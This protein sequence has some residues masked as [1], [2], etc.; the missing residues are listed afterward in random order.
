[1]A[2]L[3]FAVPGDLALPT[4]GYA[5]ARRVLQ[6]LPGLGVA[7]SHIALP[8]GYPAPTA[9]DL[10][11]TRLSLANCPPNSALMI[12]G[13]AFGAARRPSSVHFEHY[14]SRVRDLGEEPQ[15][16]CA[17]L[18]ATSWNQMLVPCR[19]CSIAEVDVREPL[20]QPFR[21]LH[22]VTAGD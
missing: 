6:L 20:L 12:D 8:A 2:Q 4:G 13:L 1:M 21:H 9:A 17:G 14:V 19:S 18:V 10:D 16:F 5:Y 7:V 22:R 15:Q 11:E 3:V